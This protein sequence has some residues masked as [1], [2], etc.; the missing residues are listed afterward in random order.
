MTSGST[1]NQ[2]R[3][4]KTSL[5]YA[6]IL[7]KAAAWGD[8]IPTY[9]LPP[10]GCR[11]AKPGEGLAHDWSI[12]SCDGRFE[13]KFQ[14]DSNLVLYKYS[15]GVAKPIWAANTWNM[16]GDK[17]IM[18]ED[19]NLVIYKSNGTPIWS[20]NTWGKPNSRLEVQDDGNVVIYSASNQPIWAT[21]TGGL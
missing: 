18:Q 15:G 6:P 8:T 14:G 17:L 13:F 19:G 10:T 20:T 3:A 7:S 21:N 9:V 2:D 4:S 12:W 11:T 1:G 5:A 16:G